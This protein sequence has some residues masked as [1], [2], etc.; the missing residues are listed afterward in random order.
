MTLQQQFE[1]LVGSSLTNLNSEDLKPVALGFWY[2]DYT[3]NLD[4][5]NSMELRRAGYLLDLFMSFNCVSD[6]RQIELMALTQKIKE[7][8]PELKLVTSSKSLDPIAQEWDLDEDIST[9]IQP[10][11]QYQTRHYVHF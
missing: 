9:A 10:L 4:K 1:N 2:E 6:L 5:M 11:L 7:N 8:L 3:P